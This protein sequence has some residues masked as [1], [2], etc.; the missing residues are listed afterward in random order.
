MLV[1]G[2]AP[3]DNSWTYMKIEGGHKYTSTG[4]SVI[5]R[6]K[7]WH[8]E[9][10]NTDGKLITKTNHASDNRGTYT[11]VL[12]SALSGGRLIIPEACMQPSIWFLVK[13]STA[14]VRILKA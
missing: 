4:G 3:K 6:E 5:V 8:V 7:P 12:P 11:P 1:E 14:S 2:F 9:F 13:K 10:Y